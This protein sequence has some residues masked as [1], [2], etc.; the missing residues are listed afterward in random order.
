MLVGCA[1]AW[2]ALAGVVAGVAV[3]V[4]SLVLQAR[5]KAPGKTVKP[6]KICRLV[7]PQRALSVGRL[8]IGLLLSSLTFYADSSLLAAHDRFRTTG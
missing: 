4:L 2:P 1:A 3:G 8:T 6:A 7:N 5:S